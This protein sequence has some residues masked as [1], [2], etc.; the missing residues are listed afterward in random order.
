MRQGFT[1]TALAALLMASATP[2][3]AQQIEA[4]RRFDIPAG[5]LSRTL[6]AFARQSSQ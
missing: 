5:P 6:P 1:S 3:C 4:A 2:V